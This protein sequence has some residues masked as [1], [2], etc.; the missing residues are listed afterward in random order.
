M[1]PSQKVRV[2]LDVNLLFNSFYELGNFIPNNWKNYFNYF[3][4][5]V[6]ISRNWATPTFWPFIVMTAS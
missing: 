5:G 1:Q 6:G 4:D 3:G 2:A